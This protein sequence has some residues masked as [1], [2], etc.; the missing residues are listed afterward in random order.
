M[1]EA[2]SL[3]RFSTWQ[4]NEGEL[5]IVKPKY[6]ALFKFMSLLSST[7]TTRSSLILDARR[8]PVMVKTL[9]F[10]SLIW[11]LFES[12][13]WR[14]LFAEIF[15]ESLRQRSTCELTCS[16]RSLMNSMKNSGPKY[17]PEE[18]HV[19]SAPHLTP[20]HPGELLASFQS[21]NTDTIQALYSRCHMPPVF[22]VIA[23]G[24][25]YQMP[26]NSQ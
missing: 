6:A 2:S 7:M 17:C 12:T 24:R 15:S 19:P 1:R 22:S 26:C 18:L 21:N 25:P 9:D 10:D 11:S 3:R 13:Q 8:F 23:H 5:S 20:F 16:G 4:S 14:I